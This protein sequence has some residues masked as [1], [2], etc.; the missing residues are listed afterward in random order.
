MPYDAM[1]TSLKLEGAVN[2]FLLID[3]WLDYNAAHS[4]QPI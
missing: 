1:L 2:R 3:K 4:E